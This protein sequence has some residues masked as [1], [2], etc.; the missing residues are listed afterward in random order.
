MQIELYTNVYVHSHK[1]TSSFRFMDEVSFVPEKIQFDVLTERNVPDIL[2]SEVKV[3]KKDSLLTLKL[4]YYDCAPHPKISIITSLDVSIAPTIKE[5]A[6]PTSPLTGMV[7]LTFDSETVSIPVKSDANQLKRILSLNTKI[8]TD[9]INIVVSSTKCYEKKWDITWVNNGGRKKLFS[10]GDKD[11]SIEKTEV[12]RVVEGKSEFEYIPGSFSQSCHKNPQISVR[13]NKI[14]ILSK[15]N[16]D[17][18]YDESLRPTVDSA[19]PVEVTSETTVTIKGTNFDTTNNGQNNNVYL[20]DINCIVLS[21][22]SVEIQC[23]VTDGVSGNKNLFVEI[24][25]KGEAKSMT[26]ISLQY[27]VKFTNVDPNVGSLGG[28]TRIQINGSGYTSDMT[29]VQI[30]AGGKICKIETI[31]TTKIICITSQNNMNSA[32]YEQDNFV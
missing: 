11:N 2:V 21:A 24:K 18:I 4:F 1:R 31:T 7:S 13:I 5:I 8:N 10:I 32:Q 22:T 14:N 16:L 12:I 29:K 25:N 30:H 27:K 20:G 17:I 26:L 9:E 23:K 3:I 15:T 6:V 28:G 19:L